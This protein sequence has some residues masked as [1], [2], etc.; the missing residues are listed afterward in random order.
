[1]YDCYLILRDVLGL[2]SNNTI[3]IRWF[4][5]SDDPSYDNEQR[6]REFVDEHPWETITWG[7]FSKPHYVIEPGSGR[8]RLTFVRQA[9]TFSHPNPGLSGQVPCLNNRKSFPRRYCQ[10]LRQSE[11]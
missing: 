2:C 8:S 6:L 7:P 1:M 4:V 9:H 3:P 10:R 11:T 5:D